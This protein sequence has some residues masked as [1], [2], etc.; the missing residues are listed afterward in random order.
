MSSF[1]RF[2]NF[3]N[4]Q[5]VPMLCNQPETWNKEKFN[6]SQA[7]VLFYMQQIHLNK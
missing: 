1:K 3:R 6:L 2:I 5:G 4:Y 7:N